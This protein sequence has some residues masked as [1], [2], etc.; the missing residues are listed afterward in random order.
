MVLETTAPE[1]PVVGQAFFLL[2]TAEL[3]TA[4]TGFRNAQGDI[5]LCAP[6]TRTK[7]LSYPDTMEEIYS[8]YSEIVHELRGGTVERKKLKY[9][10]NQILKGK[11]N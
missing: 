10:T 9:E 6:G 11:L 5:P 4:Y 2:R 7:Q 1:C 3:L 8:R